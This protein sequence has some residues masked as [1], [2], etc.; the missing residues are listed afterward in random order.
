MYSLQ[1]VGQCSN[2]I[3]LQHM[4]QSS[5]PETTQHING[6]FDDYRRYEDMVIE[7]MHQPEASYYQQ[8][9]QHPN[10][11]AQN[12]YKILKQA[13]EPLWD[14]CTKSSTLSA[15]TRL[16][17]WKSQSNISDTSFD[18]L[19]SIVKDILPI[20]K[21]L[22]NSFYETKKMLKPLKLPSQQ[23]HV[24][25]NHCMLFRGQKLGIIERRIRNK[26]RVEGS[27]VNEHLV[28][29][30]AT[31]CSLYFDPTIETCHNREARNFAPQSHRFS[32]GEAPLSIFVVPSR[33]L[34]EKS[35]KRKPLS[36][37][38][39]HKAHTYIL[40]NCKEVNPYI[41]E[42]D[43]LVMTTNP[44]ES[45]SDLRDKFFA[46]WFEDRVM[47]KTPDG[48]AKHL[49]VIAEKPSR[50]AHFHN[51]YFVNGYK[52]HTQQY[53]EGRV[54]NN[55]GVCVR[56]ETYNDEQESAYYDILQEILEVDQQNKLIDVKTNSRL[57]TDDPFCLASQAEQVFYTPYPSM[58]NETKDKWAVIKTK[59]RGVFEVNE[60]EMDAEEIF[61]G[62]ERF[63]SPGRK[64]KKRKVLKTKIMETSCFIQI[65]RKKEDYANH[66]HDAEVWVESQI[67]RTGG[68][69]KGHIYGIGASDANFVVSGITSSESTRSTQSNNNTQEEVDRLREEVSNMRQ[70]QEQMVQQM[71]RMT[72]MMNGTTNQAN[73][74][75]HTPPHT[76]PEDGV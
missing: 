34:Y 4:G 6:G 43:E 61:Q 55:F 51:G 35:G 11:E 5:N 9:P 37:K 22:P 50:H 66:R 29:E 12:F 19:L 60:A 3:P 36:D 48:S 46:E 10:L 28:N 41:L 69:K 7:S 24:C 58:A 56:G 39:L 74:P 45:V 63:E 76:P 44:N 23:I 42:F 27:I 67:R 47:D 26:A 75:P 18:R 20:G 54:T 38:D 21:K 14:G 68:K 30:L 40:L 1:E 25:I 32:S 65:R 71:E 73:D 72:R 8:T 16:L 62:E 15:T 2:P 53:G 13:S 59:P 57:Q 33:R 31:Y 52:F 70:L 17:D 64:T 49:E